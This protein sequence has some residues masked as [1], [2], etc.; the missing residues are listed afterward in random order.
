[1]LLYH[2]SYIKVEIPD[3]SFSRNNVDF[4]K[5]FYTTPLKQQAVKWGQRFNARKGQGIVSFYDFDESALQKLKILQFVDYSED[6]LEFITFC[7][8]GKPS[9]EEYDLIIGSVAN[10]KVFDTIEEYFQGYRN[11]KQAIKRLRYAEPNLQYCFKK[12]SIIDSYLKFVSFE[13]IK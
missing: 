4:G 13:V 8:M 6:W 12:Q 5:G 1:M 3:L 9:D 10:D 2:G 11:K 7:R